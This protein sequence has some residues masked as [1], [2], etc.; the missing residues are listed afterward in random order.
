MQLKCLAVDSDFDTASKYVLEWERRGV[1]MDC[2]GNMT[3]AIKM[4]Q[5]SGSDYIF[6][7]INADVIDFMPLLSTMRSITNTPILIVT[8]NFTTEKEVAALKGG[9]D[10]YARWHGSPEDNVSSVLA[11]IA[12]KATRND[13][14][15]KVFIYKNLLAAPT[16]REVFIDNEKIDFTRHELDLLLYFLS[17]QDKVLTF[18][19]I[20]SAAW[21]DIHDDFSHDAVKGLVKRLRKKFSD[22]NG[23]HIKIMNVRG[24]GYRLPPSID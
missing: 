15:H 13:E 10:L 18:E 2:A 17:N 14:P 16:Q 12:R 3:E 6:V 8:S 4:L 19:Q 21:D 20:Y 24:V 7:G 11:H 23:S 9:A 5:Q 22:N 1:S